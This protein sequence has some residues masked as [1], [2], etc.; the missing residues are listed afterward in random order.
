[1]DSRPVNGKREFRRLLLTRDY[2]RTIILRIDFP[3]K[4]E[5][6]KSFVNNISSEGLC[7][8]SKKEFT[9]SEPIN[10]RLFFYGDRIPIIK[11]QGQIV[12][13][14]RQ[15]LINYYG[16]FFEWLDEKDK[17]KLDRYIDS[18][19]EKHSYVK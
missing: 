2:N 11:I 9:E 14:K 13:K 10:L 12:W 4:S 6:I 19:V 15:N 3:N 7:F 5:S 16:V 17:L 18:K 8:E 1:M